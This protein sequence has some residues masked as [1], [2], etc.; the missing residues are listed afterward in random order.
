L[1]DDRDAAETLEKGSADHNL[2]IA[3]DSGAPVEVAYAMIIITSGCSAVQT[4]PWRL[5]LNKLV[6]MQGGWVLVVPQPEFPNGF[7]NVTTGETHPI[8]W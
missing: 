2:R 8:V 7:V 3:I 5:R 4:N 6:E 1:P